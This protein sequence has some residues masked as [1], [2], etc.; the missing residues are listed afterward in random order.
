MQRPIMDSS[1]VPITEP[2]PSRWNWRRWVVGAFVGGA[3]LLVFRP[4]SFL[5]SRD[6][7]MPLTFVG[8]LAGAIGRQLLFLP[9]ALAATA[10]ALAWAGTH[11][12]IAPITRDPASQGIYFDSVKFTA[13]DGASLSGWLVPVIDAQRVLEQKDR[14]LREHLPAVVLVHDFGQTP[15]QMLPLVRPL[16]DEGMVVL[17]LGVRG[18]GGYAR[19]GQ[20]F[21]LNESLDIRCAVE[22]LRQRRSI[23]PDRIAVVGFGTGATAA[24]LAAQRD[25]QLAALVIADPVTTASAEVSRY[26]GPTESWMHWLQP[27]C[28]WTF[29]LGYHV[30]ADDINF[31]HFAD[32]TASRPTLRL[33]AGSDQPNY[34]IP[35]RIAQ[36][37]DFLAAR[38]HP[39]S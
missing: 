29:E 38:L 7:R 20:T 33:G 17:A 13:A 19:A 36:V 12:A 2:E 6:S 39:G 4:F 3:R 10:S 25:P 1:F 32:L 24:L 34:L 14:V 5:R 22:M 9:L 11:P 31:N 21:G 28:K 23:D 26:I 35:H 8:G 15:Q 16:H 30:N 27:A 37:C 18:T